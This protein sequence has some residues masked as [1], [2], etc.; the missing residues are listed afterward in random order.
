VSRYVFL[1]AGMCALPLPVHGQILTCGTPQVTHTMRQTP[2][3]QKSVD[4]VATTSLPVAFCPIELQTEVWVDAMTTSYVTVKRSLYTA[5]ASQTRSVPTYGTWH[6]TAKHWMIMYP[7][8]FDLGKTFAQTNVI[9]PPSNAETCTLSAGDCPDGYQFESWRCDC[10]TLSPILIDTAG[11]GYKLSSAADGVEFDLNDNGTASERV[12]WTEPG[13]DDAWL[14][15]D[16]N[17]NGI[18]DSGA[19]LFGSKSPAFADERNPRAENG[20]QALFLTEGPSYGSSVADGVIDR[21]DAI[22]SRLRLWFDR[23]HNGTS[24]PD[25]L[26]PLDKAGVLA[27]NTTYKEIG[28]RDP[29]GNTFS[30]MGDGLFAAPM[31]SPVKR[32]IFDVFLTVFPAA[33]GHDISAGQ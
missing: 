6:S 12:A 19:E 13:S 3:Y 18:I 1:I 23:N 32:P 27:I 33:P 17:G 14:V 29:Y 4:V 24:E 7:T 9:A 15:L 20:F 2:N 21:K 25:E 11:D 10:V 30:L 5:A 31:G 8:W 28:R 26:V 16:R 22:Y